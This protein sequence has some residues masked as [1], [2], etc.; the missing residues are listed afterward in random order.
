MRDTIW[1]FIYDHRYRNTATAQRLPSA[2][3]SKQF[4]IT[5]HS[6]LLNF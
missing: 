5:S 6:S 1:I 2:I 3:N 4:P